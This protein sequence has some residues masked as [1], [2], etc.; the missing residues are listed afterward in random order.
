LSLRIVELG[1]FLFTLSPKPRF[2][3]CFPGHANSTHHQAEDTILEGA[4][5]P[6]TKETDD[7]IVNEIEKT[8]D[9][10]KNV[11]VSNVNA[12]LYLSE[13]SAYVPSLIPELELELIRQF[14]ADPEK[15]KIDFTSH[16]EIKSWFDM[17]ARRG[18]V[19]VTYVGSLT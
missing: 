8:D 13:I 19:F 16:G 15:L 18:M 5:N 10:T 1:I 11:S 17:I 4:R 3:C 7:A 12:G 9:R 14:D 2:P 6:T